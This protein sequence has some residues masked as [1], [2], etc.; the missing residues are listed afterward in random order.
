[1]LTTIKK[2]D[3][4]DWV[5]EKLEGRKNIEV[6]E[7]NGNYYL[8]EYKHTWD[9]KK[10]YP[11]KDV[12][13]KGVIKIKGSRIYEHGQIAFLIEIMERHGLLQKIKKY[14][15]REWKEILVFSLNRVIHPMPL[16]RMGSWM[17][18]TTL[19][20][21]LN[22]KKMTGKRISRKLGKIGMNIGNQTQFMR[23]FI[24]GGEILLYDGSIIH[25]NSTVNKL[26]EKSYDKDKLFLPKTNITL[27][28]SK[29]RN[30][31]I[32]FRIL[33]GSVHEIKSMEPILEEI[34]KNRLTFIGD[35]GYY[36]NKLFVDLD[37][38]GVDFIIPLPRDDSRIDYKKKFTGMFQF[39]ERI[40][41]FHHYLSRDYHVYT[42]EDQSLKYEET[43][44][45]Y[46]LK[47]TGKNKKKFNENWVGK[48]SILSNIE[49]DPKEIYLLW[50]S[51]DIIE[52]AFHILQN[53]L[54]TDAPY[55][56][57]EEVFRGYIFASFISLMIYYLVMNL[58]KECEINDKVGVED[59]VFEFS[60]ITFEEKKYPTISEIPK[61][62]RELA[63]KVGMKNI[64][65]KIWES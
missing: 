53:I 44:T 52:K 58:L 35:K 6:K 34:K 30:I 1:M 43:T 45:Y 19:V 62:V 26:V 64:V 14:F 40:I 10:K 31:P 28:F 37:D 32:Y 36:K 21:F 3:W 24:K 61:K 29:E 55:V 16:K 2:S 15:P 23:E 17:E 4:P 5:K 47:L 51:R 38:K 18:K 59:I 20:K 46:K 33:F 42:Y 27:L 11:V 41:K 7:S 22:V 9:K 49:D 56:S 48:I 65:T 54:E 50:K 60:R 63:K 57:K 12:S 25:S 39:K 8:Y 13:Y